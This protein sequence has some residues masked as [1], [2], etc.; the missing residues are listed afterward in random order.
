MDDFST[1]IYFLDFPFVCFVIVS[2]VWF[3]LLPIQLNRS[4]ANGKAGLTMCVSVSM[5]W[6]FESNSLELKLTFR[7]NYCLKLPPSSCSAIALHSE[8]KVRLTWHDTTRPSPSPCAEDILSMLDTQLLPLPPQLKW[9]RVTD[10]TRIYICGVVEGFFRCSFSSGVSIEML[11][12]VV[13]APSTSGW[14]EWRTRS[15]WNFCNEELLKF[16]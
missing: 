12:R 1:F 13:F 5:R 15:V 11:L 8:S 7:I 2:R 4:S 10:S 16:K 9:D 6:Q 3:N 14:L